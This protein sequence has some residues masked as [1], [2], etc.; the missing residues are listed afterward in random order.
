MEGYLHPL[1]A[2]S[3][4]EIGTPLYLPKSKGW[5]IKRQIPGT[6][7]FDAMGPY[8]LFFCENWDVL[9][10][11][12]I[13]LKNELV[14]ISLVLSPFSDF[15]INEYQD[16]F[17]IFK[18]YKDHYILDLSLPLNKTISKNKQRNAKRALRNL[19]VELKVSPNIDLDE[20]VILYNCLIELHDIDGL[21]AFSRKSFENQIAIPNTHYFRILHNRKVVGGNLFYIQG[22]VAY[23]HLSAFTEEGYELGA[24][25]AVKWVALNHL[26]KMIRWVNFGGGVDESSEKIGGLDLFKKGWSSSSEKSYFCGKI[27][28]KE[29]YEQ[30]S[31]QKS[32]NNNQWFPSYRYN[33]F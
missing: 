23:A 20:W 27:L 15:P 21:R 29:L 26:K 16:F 1:Y 5:L 11:D 3:F 4:S 32:D 19:D 14:S 25:Y 22:D 8:P 6:N 7:Y 33:D 13:G 17:E 2:E 28:N 18:V 10:E 12:F 30:L 9:I 31:I 24:A